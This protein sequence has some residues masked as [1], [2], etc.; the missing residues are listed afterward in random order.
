MRCQQRSFLKSSYYCKI[1]VKCL[2]FVCKT[3]GNVKNMRINPQISIYI[4]VYLYTNEKNYVIIYK[5]ILS[6][7]YG[8][9]KGT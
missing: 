3:Y 6:G 7:R 1:A 9:G 2:R 8:D 4:L 5:N